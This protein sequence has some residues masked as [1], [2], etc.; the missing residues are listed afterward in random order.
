[1]DEGGW[2]Y[3]FAFSKKF[4]WHGARWYN[5]FV[6]RRAWTRKRAKKKPEDLSVDPH[7][8]NGDYFNIRPASVIAKNRLSQ[9]SLSSSRVPSMTSLSSAGEMEQVKPK[10]DNIETLM[11]TLRFA[12]I[13]REKL[14][15]TGNYLENAVD[16]GQLDEEMHE[17]MALFV[18]Q[19]SRRLLLSHLM[20]FYDDTK[21]A[22][23]ENKD[24]ED[25]KE[26]QAALK[27]ALKHADEEVRR[28]AYWSDVKK[29]AENGESRGAVDGDRGWDECW[30]GVDQSGPAPPDKS[31]GPDPE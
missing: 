24:D 9:P 26:R 8:L 6:R 15:A 12:R 4:S 11:Q 29:M 31:K 2:E 7:M 20:S 22:L 3:S 1:M 17:V 16:L 21:K 30:E 13:D 27:T 28:L 10:I 18:F 5:S 14:E 19:A 25:L 23:E